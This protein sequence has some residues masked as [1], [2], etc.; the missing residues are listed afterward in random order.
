MGKRQ[1]FHSNEGKGAGKVDNE[2]RGSLPGDKVG[3]SR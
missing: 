1:E 2:E 3:G